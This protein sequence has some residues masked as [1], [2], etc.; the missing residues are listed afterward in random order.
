MF[1]FGRSNSFGSVMIL[2]F[3]SNFLFVGFDENRKKKKRK[4]GRRFGFYV[5]N[6][7][8]VGEKLRLFID[9]GKSKSKSGSIFRKKK[10][11]KEFI[12]V[13]ELIKKW[14]DC[15]IVVSRLIGG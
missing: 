4:F 9:K 1:E 5:V 12:Y 6:D 7:V 10:F 13:N 11:K 3:Y 14:F 2:F 8:F 15:R